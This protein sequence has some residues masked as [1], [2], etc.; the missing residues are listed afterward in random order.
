MLRQADAFAVQGVPGT[1][2]IGLLRGVPGIAGRCSKSRA[3]LFC[4]VWIYR[5]FVVFAR[6]GCRVVGVVPGGCGSAGGG[7][8]AFA[9]SRILIRC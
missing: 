6:L 4:G 3:Q 5:F 1:A 2:V 7:K 8:V 9:S